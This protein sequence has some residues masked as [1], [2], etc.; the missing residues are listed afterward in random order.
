MDKLFKE[1]EDVKSKYREGLINTTC[2]LKMLTNYVIKKTIDNADE[3]AEKAF[4]ASCKEA[5]KLE[6]IKQIFTQ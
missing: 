5:Q 4:K 3:I 6:R 2:A 1:I